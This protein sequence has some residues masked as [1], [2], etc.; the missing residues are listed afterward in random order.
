[1]VQTGRVV[2]VDNSDEATLTG[3][4]LAISC[5]IHIWPNVGQCSQNIALPV[6]HLQKFMGAK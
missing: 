2:S 1:M 6:A 5:T 4:V 3:A